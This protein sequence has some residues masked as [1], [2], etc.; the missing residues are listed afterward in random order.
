MVFDAR[1]AEQCAEEHSHGGDRGSHLTSVGDAPDATDAD[2][3]RSEGGHDDDRHPLQDVVHVVGQESP[4]ILRCD[5]AD[6][7]DIECP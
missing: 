5:G 7:A 4:R 6:E 3:E 1:Q 2:Y